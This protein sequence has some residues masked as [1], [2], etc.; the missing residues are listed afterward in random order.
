MS[1]KTNIGTAAATLPPIP[2]ALL[3]QL[4][5]GPMT[6][7]AIED[8]MRGFKKALIERALGAERSHH[9]GYSPGAAKPSDATNHR[10]G[11]SGK[12]VLTG[13]AAA[14]HRSAP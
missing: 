12:T 3:D 13:D 14:A 11:H 7:G 6:P 2:A 10:N 1:R 8:V 4:V 5:T 9:L